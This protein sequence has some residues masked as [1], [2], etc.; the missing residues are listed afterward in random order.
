MSEFNLPPEPNSGSKRLPFNV[1]LPV[2]PTPKKAFVIGASGLKG[3]IDGAIMKAHEPTFI[4]GDPIIGTSYLGTPIYG[5]IIIKDTIDR[6]VSSSGFSGDGWARFQTCASV[7]DKP[8]NI[9]RTP[10]H[11]RNGTVK[12]YISDDDYHI[13]IYGEIVSITPDVAP[14]VDV[15][16]INDLCTLPNEIIIVSDFIHSFGVTNCVVEHFNCRQVKGTRNVI[17]FT[18]RLLSDD[19]TEVQL[20]I[21]NN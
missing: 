9:V 2:L 7:V 14:H 16:N 3:A 18:M 13:E 10:V 12:E 19:P 21:T 6:V 17:E 1:P 15:K 11:G 5:E 4:D 8:R 20:G